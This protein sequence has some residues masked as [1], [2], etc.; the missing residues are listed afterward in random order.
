MT[1]DTTP[2]AKKRS[3]FIRIAK[4]AAFLIVLIII[5]GIA[6]PFMIPIE[7][8]KEPL[9]KKIEQVSGAKVSI[10]GPMSFSLLPQIA[11]QLEQ[12]SV[13]GPMLPKT[14]P[15]A[16][17]KKLDLALAFWPLLRG[18]V[19]VGKLILD[20]PKI[21]LFVAKDGTQNWQF[22]PGKEQAV[23]AAK[24]DAGENPLR[25]LEQLQIGKLEINDGD[26]LYTNEQ[27]GKIY[28]LKDLDMSLKMPG[29]SKPM[30]AS[31]AADYNGQR[32]SSSIKAENLAAIINGATSDIEFDAKTKS[33]QTTFKG[34]ISAA[35]EKTIQGHL[36]SQISDLPGFISWATGKPSS[37]MVVRSVKLDTDLKASQSRAEL[38]SLNFSA[39]RTSLTGNLSANLK[40]ARPFIKGTVNVPTLDLDAFMPPS[41]AET[42]SASS[43]A[44][45][46]SWSRE[47]IDTSSFRLADAQMVLSITNLIY[48]K[49]VIGPL[50][51]DARL[52]NGVMHIKTTEAKAFGGN[53]NADVNLD[54]SGR[55]LRMQTAA[56][57]GGVQMEKMLKM[58]AGSDRLS[59]IGKGEANLQSSGSSQMELM[60]NL[61]GKG[62][63]VF[64]DGAIK[65][66]N[67]A[68]MMR[69]ISTAFV[70][71]HQEEKT[72]FAELSGNFTAA[73]GNINNDLNL[74]APVLRVVGNGKVNMPERK[75]RYYLEPKVV[76]TLK[77]QGGAMDLGG[78]TVPVIVSGTF[79]NISYT[80][81]L[82]AAMAKN[83]IPTPEG[84]VKGVKGITEGAGGAIKVPG[85]ILQGIFGAPAEQP[86]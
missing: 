51:V 78:I 6:L 1:T 22:K 24:T 81:D 8:Y 16:Q 85:Q 66:I 14:Q 73:N 13:R 84:V 17:V 49:E 50:A 55:T 57:F 3:L 29:F 35:S 52:N 46:K 80:P 10:D 41:T 18:Q 33:M 42:P 71:D 43:K 12:V 20:E 53:L 64:N 76:G 77:G 39:D 75:L 62:N 86:K 5:A 60:Q 70:P 27:A 7:K 9:L 19:Q 2:T 36:S 59:G 34:T 23:T 40:P 25:K 65:G 69:N 38:T 31:I 21:N 32:V 56:N 83:V 67:L 15:L 79:D 37:P 45:P 54:A 26:V 82:A 28:S 48:N 47:P 68:A 63:F 61:G 11:I 4:I 30:S 58:L 72:D 44:A 74:M